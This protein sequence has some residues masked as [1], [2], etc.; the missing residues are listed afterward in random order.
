MW[1]TY[2]LQ[3]WKHLAAVA[4]IATVSLVSYSKGADSVR[5]EWK[6]A[7]AELEAERLKAEI[8]Q[9]K[10]LQS[11]QETK[12][13]N[14]AEIDRLR[15]NNHALWLR[16]PKTP[17]PGSVSDN[18]AIASGVASTGQLYDPLPS[19]AEQAINRFD[20]AWRGEAYRA[21]KLIEDCRARL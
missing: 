10:N 6:L 16:L 17:C 21:D 13:A 7:N 8:E 19:R 18:T 15:A 5:Q 14:L 3:Y 2:L 11:L 9:R 12:S 20:E 1:L 4:L